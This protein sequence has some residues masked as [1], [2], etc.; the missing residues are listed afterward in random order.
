MKIYVEEN[1]ARTAVYYP[2]DGGFIVV[3]FD[4]RGNNPLV[5]KTDRITPHDGYVADIADADGIYN[6]LLGNHACEMRG[7]SFD[8]DT[9][10]WPAARELA[11]RTRMALGAIR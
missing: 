7:T 2:L 9:M 3:S 1:D 4:R 6:V 5:R 10:T 11:A 8:P